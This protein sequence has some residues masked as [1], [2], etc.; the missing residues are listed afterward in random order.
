MDNKSKY[1]GIFYDFN[2]EGLNYD[3][4]IYST[5]LK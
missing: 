4:I 2:H 5:E 3:C 1:I